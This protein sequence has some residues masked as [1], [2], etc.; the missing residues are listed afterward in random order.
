MG[1]KEREQG[2]STTRQAVVGVEWNKWIW[3]ELGSQLTETAVTGSASPLYPVAHDLS[4]VAYAQ[5]TVAYAT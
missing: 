3:T 1:P 2:N 4:S 5:F